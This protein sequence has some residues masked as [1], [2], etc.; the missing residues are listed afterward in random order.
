MNKNWYNEKQQMG[1]AF[2]S[3]DEKEFNGILNYLLKKS[4]RLIEK[5]VEITASNAQTDSYF[6][7]Q[8][9]VL[10]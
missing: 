4:N 5:V 6:L 7:P 9:V 3:S 8:N 1:E 10:F 2:E